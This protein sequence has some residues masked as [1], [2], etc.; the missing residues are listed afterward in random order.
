MYTDSRGRKRPVTPRVPLKAANIMPK[1]KGFW[2]EKNGERIWIAG[3]EDRPSSLNSMPK[4]VKERSGIIIWDDGEKEKPYMVR[5]YQIEK[6]FDSVEK[7]ER[8]IDEIT[9]ETNPLVHSENRPDRKYG[10]E[11]RA[12]PLDNTRKREGITET[13]VTNSKQGIKGYISKKADGTYEYAIVNHGK[14]PGK[15]EGVMPAFGHTESLED[16]RSI[17]DNGL[18]KYWDTPVADSPHLYRNGTESRERRKFESEYGK[19]KGDYVYGAVVRK[20]R[21]ER[22]AKGRK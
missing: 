11:Y 15:T 19:E 16:A 12:V 4:P 3:K 21:R 20:V 18:W 14:D 8:F 17:I 6:K 10:I 2:I 5:W 13:Y 7:A 9:E 22:L 1:D